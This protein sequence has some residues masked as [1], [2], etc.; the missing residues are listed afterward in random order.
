MFDDGNAIF[1][2][3]T[4][5]QVARAT[6]ASILPQHLEQTRNQYIYVRSA[7]WTQNEV[8]RLMQKYT[9]TEFKDWTFDHTKATEL[10]ARSQKMF[11]D[12]ISSGKTPGELE[13]SENFQ[14]SIASLIAATA[15]GNRSF[16]QFGDKTEVWMSKLGLEEE[17]PDDVVR[18]FVKRSQN[19]V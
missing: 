10:A 5:A 16:N 6:V 13:F 1:E 3:S 14:N 9:H 7:L 12:E 15:L 18:T 11:S 17:Q 4:T 8:L 2:G 19:K